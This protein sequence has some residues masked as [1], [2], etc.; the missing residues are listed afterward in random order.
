M[1]G[2]RQHHTDTQRWDRQSGGC[3]T[4][5][6]AVALTLGV[7]LG[8]PPP[9]H[10]RTFLCGAGDVDC[11]S[12]AITTANANGQTN[13][14]RLEAGT[15]PLMEDLPVMTSPLTIKGDGATS[16]KH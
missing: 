4:W 14:I 7:A 9:A 11:L 16:T 3:R 13:T 10:A 12:N 6:I 2:R 15:Y 5:S 1:H 8:T